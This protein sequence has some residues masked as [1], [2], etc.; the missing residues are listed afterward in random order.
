MKNM[1]LIEEILLFMK[2]S[3]KKSFSVDELSEG[4]GYTSANDFKKL[5]GTLAQLEREGQ[6]NLNKKNRFMLSMEQTLVKGLF[7]GNDRGFGFV[8]TEDDQDDIYIPQGATGYALDGDQVAVEITRE[9]APWQDKGAEGRVV[10]IEERRFTQ[11]VGE[12]I[13]YPE[14]EVAETELYG[15]VVPK[16]KKMATYRV[17]IEATG[18]QPVEGSIVLV[19][20]TYYPDAEFPTSM[21]GI[22]KKTIGHINDPGIDI[23]SI[24]YKFGIPTEFE[25]ST[26]KQA[27]AVSDTIAESDLKDRIDLRQETIVTIDGEDAKDLDDAVTVRKL[28]NGRYHLGVHIADVSYYV[29]ED[30]PLDQEAFE[31]GTSVYLTDRVIP[32]IP[33]R[34]SNGICSLNPAVPRLT[35]SCEMEIDQAGNVVSHRIFPSVIQTTARMTYTAVNQILM[36]KDETVR[37][38]YQELVPMFELMGELHQILENKRKQRGAI[39]FEAPEAQIIVDET[40]Q[41]IDIEL[42]ERGLG[43]RLIESFMLA[44]N[45]TVAEHF[46]T[47]NVPFIYRIHE[48]PDSEKMQRFAEFITNFGV[49]LKGTNDKIEPK[50][51]QNV[52]ASI[53]GE[54][55]EP[56]IAT[57]LLRS[58][59]QAK[60]DVEPLGHFGLAAEYYTHFTSP[61]RRYPDL[62]VHRLIRAYATNGTGVKEQAKW[63]GLLPDISEQSSKMERRA[64]EAERETDALKKAAYMQD[65]VGEIYEGVVS[66][67]TKF[68]IFVELPNTVEGL[69]HISNMKEDYFDYIENHMMLI[70]ERTGI[71]YRIGQPVKIE[72]VKA[73]IETKEIDFAIVPDESKQ[74]FASKNE[75]ALKKKTSKQK[76]NTGNREQG[77]G[78]NSPSTGRKQERSFK[79]D[80]KFAK[81]KKKKGKKPFYKGVAKKKK[82]K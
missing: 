42:R 23:L 78:K 14:A 8:I 7:R 22:V 12:F 49:L 52:L 82:K 20:L 66:S 9:A 30:S 68:G 65:K 37:E 59:K 5:V 73:D 64:V 72:V 25:E 32:M 48:Q 39:D 44:A 41:P 71:S 34:L 31:R 3:Q 6:L 27:E 56:I 81:G 69:I 15:Y 51:L 4:L 77:R 17:Y 11:L 26:L 40:G 60:Y 54:P 19:E 76:K 29:T 67:V 1:K 58:M 13:P 47:L 46:A 21:Q 18:I 80:D 35:M 28:E 75:V 61:I 57:M 74:R 43:E 45:E 38:T 50:A 62:I 70:G 63:E 33:H 10:G 2:Q 16:D 55:E 53:Q 24:V 79:N 36:E